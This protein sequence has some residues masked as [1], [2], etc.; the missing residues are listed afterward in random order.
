MYNSNFT[1]L[2]TIVKPGNT[3]FIQ[4]NGIARV[5]LWDKTK[6]Y[7]SGALVLHAG[8]LYSATQAVD[9]G[10]DIGNTKYWQCLTY[11]IVDL[12]T[13][14]QT[15]SDNKL[16][17]LTD[18]TYHDQAY[19]KTSHGAQSTI[20]IASGTGAQPNRLA[21]YDNNT[22]LLVNVIDDDGH[23]QCAVNRGFV[24][25]KLSTKLDKATNVSQILYG[26]DENGD[27][28]YWR[29]GSAATG[30]SMV[31]RSG[32][33][34]CDI[35][36][37]IKPF[38]IANKKYVDTGLDG[39]LDLIEP[40]SKQ[41]DFVTI[42]KDDN[43]YYQYQAAGS[44]TPKTS[45]SDF[46]PV[47]R[48]QNGQLRTQM[49][50]SPN[51]LDAINFKYLNERLSNINTG[52]SGTTVT[53]G[54]EAQDTWNADTKLDKATSVV[55]GFNL[56]GTKYNDPTTQMWQ[57]DSGNATQSRIPM[58]FI[59]DN[60][61]VNENGKGCLVTSTPKYDAHAANKKYVDDGLSGK[62]PITPD[63]FP[64]TYAGLFGKTGAGEIEIVTKTSY[65]D[66]IENETINANGSV[67]SYSWRSA[68]KQSVL[69][70]GIPDMPHQAANKLYVDTGLDGKLDKVTEA[71]KI[72][73]TDENGNQIVYHTGWSASSS[74]FQIM[75]HTPNG[76]YN[77]DG[78]FNDG[79]TGT[80][81]VAIP[82]KP[83]HATPK[84]WVED[85]FTIYKHLIQLD[86]G[87]S[88]PPHI[89]NVLSTRST[90]Y[91]N[92]SELPKNEIFTIVDSAFEQVQF[93]QIYSDNYVSG[94]EYNHNARA[95]NDINGTISSF[96][97]IDSDIVTKA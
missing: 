32:D 22:T 80:Y 41:I 52:G 70:T 97:A 24:K 57:I 40:D 91:T 21:R 76:G 58:Y 56:Y 6:T 79:A 63:G 49:V 59:A 28:S 7:P 85:N 66:G 93:V 83:S 2:T 73:G 71:Y 31:Y 77:D 34:T 48:G 35:A 51:D 14:I 53:V 55:G 36:D 67:A 95:W 88:S 19:I 4:A 84:K 90:P 60:A 82:K 12:A 69:Y 30:F 81:M 25:D 27:T 8:Y 13:R 78:S 61:N 11:P 18:A 42:K 94:I 39:K 17:K 87:E 68:T 65:W 89:F 9:S 38:N 1:E 20:D 50:A 47:L 3:T 86:M 23:D 29:F 26:T 92:A 96:F 44:F 72:Y 5:N 45:Y 43:G 37:P 64:E 62:V 46:T 74:I 10:I 75:D 16:D 54:G 33:G 15:L